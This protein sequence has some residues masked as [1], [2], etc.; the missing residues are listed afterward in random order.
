VDR[1]TKN[2]VQRLRPN[3]IAVIDH[4]DLDPVAADALKR[5]HPR[6]IINASASLTGR[7]PN[8]GPLLL[9]RAG[10]PILDG[11][12][13]EI[14]DL[15]REGEEIEIRDDGVYCGDRRLASGFL[16]TAR[17]V[18]ELLA[19]AQANFPKEVA[20]F[21]ENTLHYA[22]GE[23][24]AVLQGLEIPPLGVDFRG[25]QVLVVVRGDHYRE[26]LRA[27]R[28][29]IQE[30]RPVLVGVDGGADA[31][32]ECGYRPQVIV[33]DMD[34]VSDRA[35]RCGAELIVHAYPDGRAPGKA[36][37]AALGLEGKV[38]RAPGT[39]E[40][41]A[42]L[43][44]HQLGAALIVI[45]GSHF[46]VLDFLS[47][48]RRGMASTLLVRLKVGSL[49]VDAKGVSLLYRERFHLGMLLELILAALVPAFLLLLAAP[50]TQQLLRLAALRLRLAFGF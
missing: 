40:D 50:V 11:V 5:C 4:P 27:I 8:A 37:L 30:N 33:G 12:G 15:V 36:R 25:R 24:D 10:I 20:R 43:L 32:L 13:A 39:S 1:R 16:L 29:Y 47:K 6:A 42:L 22:L 49:L 44:A 41:L 45:V 18:E 19:S 17:R 26:D 23:V 46:G 34:S 48:G 31:L 3:E 35:L 7:Y 14:F 21:I 2:L 38:V 9:L 28:T